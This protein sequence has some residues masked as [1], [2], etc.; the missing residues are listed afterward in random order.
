MLQRLYLLKSCVQ[1]ALIDISLPEGKPFSFSKNQIK[2]ISAIF[3]ALVP[4]K[5][6]VAALCRRDAKKVHRQRCHNFYDN[7][8]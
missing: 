8:T 1:K 6:T 3:K 4:I 7:K 2:M 5:A